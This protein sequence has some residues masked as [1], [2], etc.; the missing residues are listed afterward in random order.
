MHERQSLDPTREITPDEFAYSLDGESYSAET[1]ST[2][3]EAL[4]FVSDLARRR[5]VDTVWTA[6]AGPT[7]VRDPLRADVA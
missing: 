5:N 1:Y 2:R 7:H 3:A 6:L 4:I